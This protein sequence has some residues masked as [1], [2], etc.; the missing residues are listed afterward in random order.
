VALADGPA[1]QARAASREYLRWAEGARRGAEILDACMLLAA[2]A[3]P[4]ERVEW[5]E[6]GTSQALELDA[7]AELGRA[8]GELAHALDQL[9]RTEQA[10]AAYEQSRRWH[11]ARGRG[12]E[13]VAA[14]WAVGALACRLEEWP[15]GRSALEEAI[16]EGERRTDCEDLVALALADLATVYE[17]AGD[18]VEARR[19]LLRALAR[20]REQHLAEQWPDRW[21]A[22]RRYARRLELE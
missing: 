5:L 8:T 14:G 19:I 20:G 22:I 10:L 16:A 11:R 13:A 21:E 18:V 15:L 12:R 9:G 4:A 2:G 1:D 7:T 3:S 6:R 17:A